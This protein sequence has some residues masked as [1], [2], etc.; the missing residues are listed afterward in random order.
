MRTR[1]ILLFLTCSAFILTGCGVTAIPP[2]ITQIKQEQN[3]TLIIPKN[4]YRESNHVTYYDTKTKAISSGEE[5]NKYDPYFHGL[6]LEQ[7]L[8]SYGDK[9]PYSVRGIE[10][11]FKDNEMK[12]AK[13][14][15][16][17]YSNGKSFYSET[18][19]LLKI[20]S[21]EMEDRWEVK[22]IPYEKTVVQEKDPLFINYKIP[23]FEYGEL[24]DSLKN[25]KF[26]ITFD[27][28]SKY[29]TDSL[30]ANFKRLLKQKNPNGKYYQSR[31]SDCDINIM[32]E[33]FP[34]QNGSKVIGNIEAKCNASSDV[35]DVVSLKQDVKKY[36]D[37]IINN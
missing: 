24:I 20:I 28:N 30:K 26:T 17:Q 5:Y 32:A 27:E 13:L 35:I 15:G 1:I 25:I 29:G 37:E 2:V 7:Q 23:T 31:T 10:F 36:L 14:N 6:E 34:Y 18:S 3:I 8:Y 33:F 12:V 22:L 11:T 19:Y 4:L 21:V 16:E 9:Y